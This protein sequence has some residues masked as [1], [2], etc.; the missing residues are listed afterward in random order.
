[1]AKSRTPDSSEFFMPLLTFFRENSRWVAGGFLLTLFSGFG[2][3]FFISLSAGEI[4]SEFGLSHGGFGGLYM[5]ATL[6]SA[7]TLPILGKVV[8]MIT[9]ARVAAF[10][11]P[12]LMLATVSMAMAGNVIWLGVTIY[13]LRLFGQGMMTHIAMTAMG[14]WF[15]AQRGRAVSLATLGHNVGEAVFPSVFVVAGLALG[16]RGAWLAA[17]LVLVLVALPAIYLLMRVERVPRETDTPSERPSVRDWTRPEVLRDPLFWMALSGILAPGF[18]GTTVFF[19][20][21]YLSEL[22]GWPPGVFA[23]AFIVMSVMTIIFALISGQLIDRFS[24]VRILPAFLLPLAAS[25]VVLALSVSP[26][27]AYGFM[28]LMGISYG[29]SSTLFGAL[30]PELYGIKHLGAIRAVV[31][32]LMVFATAAGPGLTGW[33]IDNG[34]SYPAQIMG[35]GLYCLVASVMMI[36]VSRKASTRE[37]AI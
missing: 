17:A 14:R 7:L 6:A 35:M 23:S 12:A 36:V 1:M 26:V 3:T 8:D 2:Q 24:A 28:A 20:Q 11:I 27:G 16:W 21:V 5:V 13:A 22:R 29:F 9:I 31:V 4:R 25:C 19:H 15:A 32:A 18:I 10:T 30:W 33:L 34:V 37:L